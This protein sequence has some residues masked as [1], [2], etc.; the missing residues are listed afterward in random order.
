MKTKKKHGVKRP[1]TLNP[2]G[3]NSATLLRPG[4]MEK[5]RHEKRKRKENQEE[6]IAHKE[7]LN[8]FRKNELTDEDHLLSG[9][10]K[11][12]RKSSQRG[13]QGRSKEK[14][15]RRKGRYKQS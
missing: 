3:K 1:T 5:R 2:S 10:K 12:P 13:V 4:V 7:S 15:I 8:C 6:R 11:P 9:S 14:E